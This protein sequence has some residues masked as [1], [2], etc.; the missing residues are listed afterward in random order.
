MK[1]RNLMLL[2]AALVIGATAC[3]KDPVNPDDENNKPDDG[4]KDDEVEKVEVAEVTIDPATLELHPGEIGQLNATV[5][6][7]NAEDKTLVWSSAD[8]SIVVVDQ[9]GKV[10]ALA[11]GKAT[12]KAVSVNGIEGVCE[13]S[14]VQIPVESI[15]LNAEKQEIGV[16]ETFQ[17]TATITPEEAADRKIEWNSTAA[18][19]ASVD[20]NGLVTAKEIG[21]AVIT[22]SLEGKSASCVITVI[23]Q[24]VVGDYYYSDGSFSSELDASKMPIGLVFWAG[25]PSV[26]D[27]ALRAE[28]PECTHGLVVS[29]VDVKTDVRWQI[30]N[31]KYGKTVGEWIEQNTDYQTTI[32]GA[33]LGDYVN[34]IVGYNNTKGMEAFNAAPENADWTLDPIK[35]IIRFRTDV[36]A[37]EKSSD[38]YLPSVMEL[39]LMC[40]GERE[41]NVL[42]ITYDDDVMKLLNEKIATITGAHILDDAYT[43]SSEV[44]TYNIYD[45]TFY[46]AYIQNSGKTLGERVR[47]VLAF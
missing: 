45:M 44:D 33:N 5:T 3:T 35:E 39:S 15:A 27:A 41:G 24:P 29:L 28:H 34:D 22:A 18:E 26:K 17:L 8:E 46:M 21:N 40:S 13:V 36:P 1:L 42:E 2:F 11:L 20:E 4:N 16:G 43:S 47:A 37:P 23:A 6:P 7:E 9:Q 31:M 30:A 10:N 12:V 19:I 32:A 25:N 38:W 14:V